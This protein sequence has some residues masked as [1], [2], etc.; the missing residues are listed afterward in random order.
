MKKSIMYVVVCTMVLI[1]VAGCAAQPT[2]CRR[3]G[4]AALGAS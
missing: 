1:L 4:P 2:G 3:A